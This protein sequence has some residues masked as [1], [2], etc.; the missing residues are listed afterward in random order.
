MTDE[1]YSLPVEE[2]QKRLRRALTELREASDSF[3]QSRAA[4]K[5]D[6][7]MDLITFSENLAKKDERNKGIVYR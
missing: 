6:A 3:L 7:L 5:V 1:N 4:G 2:L